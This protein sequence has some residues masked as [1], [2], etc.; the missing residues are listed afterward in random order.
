MGQETSIWKIAAS[1]RRHF[2][3]PEEMWDKALAYFK[4]CEDNPLYKTEQMKSPDKTPITIDENTPS[5]PSERLIEIPLKRAFTWA[6]FS[7]FCGVSQ[8][9]FRKIKSEGPVDEARKLW[10]EVVYRIDDAI[11]TQQYEGGASG[12]LNAAIVA[13]GIGLV[14]KTQV[15]ATVTEK[16]QVFKI[17]NQVFEL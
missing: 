11:F 4:W 7:I 1:P 8:G 5:V 2:D 13:R 3:S 16:K 14:D 6:A 12:Q 9:Y 10:L 15:D 17:G